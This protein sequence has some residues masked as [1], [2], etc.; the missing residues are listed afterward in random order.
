LKVNGG[1]PHKKK[2]KKKQA[3]FKEATKEKLEKRLHLI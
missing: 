1:S 3:H 2:K